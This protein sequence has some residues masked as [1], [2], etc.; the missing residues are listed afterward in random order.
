MKA[1]I[2]QSIK[3]EYQVLRQLRLIDLFVGGWGGRERREEEKME[4][5]VGR[6]GEGEGGE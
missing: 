1:S 2:N 3:Q 6:E 4:T 5:A